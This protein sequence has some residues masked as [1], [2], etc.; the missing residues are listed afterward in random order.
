LLWV[1]CLMV[2]LTQLSAILH[3][4]SC[5]TFRSLWLS[6]NKHLPQKDHIYVQSVT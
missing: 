5:H 2:F 4:G 3:A 6:F 1:N